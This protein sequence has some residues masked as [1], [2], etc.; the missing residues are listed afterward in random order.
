MNRKLW[1][2]VSLISGIIGF[3]SG[4][5]LLGYAVFGSVGSLFISNSLTFIAGLLLGG[6]D[7]V[8]FISSYFKAKKDKKIQHSKEY[9]AVYLK[10]KNDTTINFCCGTYECNLQVESRRPSVSQKEKAVCTCI[11]EHLR[12][13]Y[14]DVWGNLEEIDENINPKNLISQ[15]NNKAQDFLLRLNNSLLSYIQKEIPDI[16]AW[17]ENGEP[18][19]KYF[20]KHFSKQIGFAFLWFY[21]HPIDDIES[22]L[23]G[24][25][26]IKPEKGLS[27]K[28][29]KTIYGNNDWVAFDNETKMKEVHHGIIQIIS[30]ALKTDEFKDLKKMQTHIQDRRDDFIMELTKIELTIDTDIPLKAECSICKSF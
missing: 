25:I 21:K 24:N 13:D 9:M 8:G 29:L 5:L 14:K 23:L 12:S 19:K 17:D 18:P 15:Y 1:I 3:I 22:R 6:S 16:T 26:L 30:N 27:D 2:V 7:L 28:G 20:T 4:Y 10:N 11:E